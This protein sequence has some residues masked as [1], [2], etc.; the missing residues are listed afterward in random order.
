MNEQEYRNRGRSGHPAGNDESHLRPDVASPLS[1]DS[2]FPL[3]PSVVRG[4]LSANP[5]HP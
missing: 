3:F 1:G 4:I 2:S 5:E